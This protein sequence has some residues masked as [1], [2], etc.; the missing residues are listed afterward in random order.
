M[1]IFKPVKINLVKKKRV[2]R[3]ISAGQG[4]TAGRGT[5]GQKSRSGFNIPRRFEGG[6]SSLISRIPKKKGF[7]TGLIKPTTISTN[8][9]VN[10]KEGE[11]VSP[12]T[13]FNKGIIKSTKTKVKIVLGKEK[14]NK[15]RFQ[16]LKFSQSVASLSV[17]KT[18]SK[19]KS[20]N[21]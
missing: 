6:Q 14:I 21:A 20:K 16:Q 2:G 11:V 13:L 3:G 8:K 19:T 10:F 4:K 5:K 9:L 7:K 17:T 15:L 1:S 12:K 18:E